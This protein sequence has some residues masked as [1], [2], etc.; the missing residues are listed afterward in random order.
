ML[1]PGVDPIPRPSAVYLDAVESVS[2]GVLVERLGRL[3]DERM[4]QVCDALESRWPARA[5]PPR[6]RVGPGAPPANGNE[7]C[8]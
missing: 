1:S 5:D 8:G 7:R 6:L 3:S 4:A 2:V